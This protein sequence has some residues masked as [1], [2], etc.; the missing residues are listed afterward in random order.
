VWEQHHKRGG[1]DDKARDQTLRGVGV[2]AAGVLGFLLGPS[3][4]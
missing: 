4:Q 1:C 2:A 3:Q